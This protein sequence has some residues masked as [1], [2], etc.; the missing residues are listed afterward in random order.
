MTVSWETGME[1]A[2]AGVFLGQF[3][4]K[5]DQAGTGHPPLG[6]LTEKRPISPVLFI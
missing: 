1:Q 3:K 4:G 6:V 2:Q 5:L